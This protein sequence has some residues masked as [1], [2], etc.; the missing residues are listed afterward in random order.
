MTR[1]ECVRSHDAWRMRPYSAASWFAS[2]I[3]FG[4]VQRSTGA[5]AAAS[6]RA[7]GAARRYGAP[8]KRS[9]SP[10]CTLKARSRSV[11]M[12]RS[13]EA[14]RFRFGRLD[15]HGAVHDERE[16]HRHRM[17]ALVDHR[18]GEIERGDAGALQPGVV[19]QHLVHAGRSPKGADIT[20]RR[21]GAHVVGVEHRVFRRLPHAVGAM[22]EHVGRARAR[23]CPSGHG[24]RS[25][26]RRLC[27]PS[28]CSTSANSS[29]SC[30]DEGHRREGRE[31][32]PRARPGR[33]PD[34]RRHAASRRSCA[35]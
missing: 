24:R 4:F 21:R 10:R 5:R 15:Q 3:G 30:A 26:G 12:N 25:C 2:A 22:R 17:I 16:I 14:L 8:V 6:R 9:V 11:A 32:L 33:R 7:G 31:A 28:A 20:S 27:V 35:G 23:T 34:R 1:G 18:L 29:P 19:E 13:S